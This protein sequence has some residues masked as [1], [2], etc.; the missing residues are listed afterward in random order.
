MAY[1]FYINN[2]NCFG[3]KT[4]SMA[5]KNEKQSAKGVM[6]R[7]V[8]EIVQ[9]EPPALSFLSMACNHCDEPACLDNC[10]AGAY[11][12]NEDGIVI[13]NHDRC[14]G[15]QTCI[16]VC[17]YAAPSYDESEGKTHKCDMCVNRLE[18]D[19]LP[20]CVESCPGLYLAVGEMSELMDTY[21]A[22]YVSDENVATAPNFVITADPL[23]T[24]EPAQAALV[25]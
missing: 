14:I 6:L 11:E 9:D 2:D 21:K 20:A 19:R 15:C 18:Q 10:P 25:E 3:C 16:D 17:P 13:Q 1:G 24:T 23:L 7:R 4:C 22:D 12:K 5:C 8:R